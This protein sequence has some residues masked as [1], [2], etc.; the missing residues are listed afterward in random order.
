MEKYMYA[1]KNYP[2]DHCDRAI[3]PG[4][5]YLFGKGRGPR[6]LDS[7]INNDNVQV[8]IEYYQYRLC[9]KRDCKEV[10]GLANEI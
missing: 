6:Y 2:C 10:V 3:V 4:E 1:Q 9:L 5:L 7:D 8:G